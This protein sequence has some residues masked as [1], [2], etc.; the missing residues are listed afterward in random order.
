MKQHRERGGG[1]QRERDTTEREREK[2][3]ERKNF[4]QP[5]IAFEELNTNECITIL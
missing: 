2:E 3:R 1:S 5:Q 4:F